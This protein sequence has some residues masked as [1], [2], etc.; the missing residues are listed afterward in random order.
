M[1][2]ANGSQ[3]F[4]VDPVKKDDCAASVRRLVRDRVDAPLATLSVHAVGLLPA[5]AQTAI[6]VVADVPLQPRQGHRGRGFS[7]RSNGYA[8]HL[9][10]FHCPPRSTLHGCS[11]QRHRKSDRRTSAPRSRNVLEIVLGTDR[12][13]A[14]TFYRPRSRSR[15]FLDTGDPVPASVYTRPSCL[16]DCPKS[17]DRR[18]RKD[19]L[20]CTRTPNRSAIAP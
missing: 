4:S 15:F 7:R 6:A 10:L 12:C 19:L 20:S 18:Q 2:G 17:S 9:V 14:W 16:F 5:D 1:A 13:R 11:L 8:S 3:R